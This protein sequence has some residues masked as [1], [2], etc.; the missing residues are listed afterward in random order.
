[1]PTDA[2]NVCSWG[3]IGSD[4]R[5]GKPTLMTRNGHGRVFIDPG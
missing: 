4:R 5:I 1:M 3:K 2:A